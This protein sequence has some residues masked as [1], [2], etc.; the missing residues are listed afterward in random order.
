M[1]SW[2]RPATWR[3][4]RATWTPAS[5]STPGR[6]RALGAAGQPL[7]QLYGRT[8]VINMFQPVG[9]NQ[10]NSLQARLERRFSNGFQFAASYTWSKAIG[11]AANDDSGLREPA[12]AYWALNRAV[13]NFDRTQN[14]QLQGMWDLPFGKGKPWLSHGLA[15]T[16][17]GGWRLN[18]IA[19]FMTGLP[20]FVSASGSSLNM[21]GATQRANQLKQSVQIVGVT[22]AVLR[23]TSI[24]WH[25]RRS[26][27]R[28]SATRASTRSVV[29][30]L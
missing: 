16:M 26:L 5:I 8:A 17:A 10:Y 28:P 18:G 13:L 12:P 20:F 21:P 3:L 9:T 29:R 24:P 4:E 15:S 30:A 1:D 22:S 25:S 14:L 6:F 7:N 27:R 19:S 11:M 23:R 2:R